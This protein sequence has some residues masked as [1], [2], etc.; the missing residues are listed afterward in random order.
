MRI[1][2]AAIDHNMHLSNENQLSTSGEERGHRKYSKQTQKIHAE[3]VK[4]EKKIT[5]SFP[6]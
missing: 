1:M 5:V 4:K 2:L 3:V 6:S